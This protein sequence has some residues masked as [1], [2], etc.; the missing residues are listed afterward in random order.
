MK[1]AF[2]TAGIPSQSPT[3]YR[4]IHFLAG[5]PAAL[6]E[7]P[8]DLKITE[9]RPTQNASVSEKKAPP[10]TRLLILRDIE[11]ERARQTA[12]ADFVAS[13]SDFDPIQIRDESGTSWTESHLSG[14]RE[15][16]TAQSVAEVL[17]RYGIERVIA[18]RSLPLL[19]A[20][21]IQRVGIMVVCDPERGILERRQKADWEIEAVRH[22]QAVTESVMESTCRWVA[23]AKVVGDGILVQDGEPLTSERVRVWIDHRLLDAGFANPMS[24]I[25]A[26]GRDGGD[27]HALGSGPLRTGE[28]VI[29]DIFPQDKSSLYYGDCTRTV[30]HGEIAPIYQKMVEAVREAK[31]AA[32]ETIRPGVTGEAVHRATIATLER[33]GFGYATP[34]SEEAEN[35]IRLTHGTGHGLGLSCHE[36]PLLDLGGPSLMAGDIVSVEPG[37]Y[38]KKLGGIRIEDMVLVTDHGAENLGRPLPE[39]LIWK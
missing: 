5:D 29:I 13:P 30:I 16:A 12:L 4:E 26:G 11:T 15:T 1:E 23:T 27:C 34:G 37:L 10:Q 38:S 8:G 7:F 6:L 25:V 39:T 36:P 31:R 35:E 9:G 22:S 21:M 3:L 2:L 17:R 14:D 28:P 33:F 19:Y 32:T 20:E 18:D 24:S